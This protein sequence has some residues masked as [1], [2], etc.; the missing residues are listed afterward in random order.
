[1]SIARWFTTS[2]THYP[3]AGVDA[4]G[5]PQFSAGV[6]I[7]ARV[8]SDTRLGVGLMGDTTTPQFVIDSLTAIAVGDEVQV[9]SD[10]RA[11]IIASEARRDHHGRVTHYR[12]RMTSR[13]TA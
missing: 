9:G 7:K 2:V 10:P 8:L 11:R 5:D 4:Y 12:A 1:M 6:T 3:Q 13:V